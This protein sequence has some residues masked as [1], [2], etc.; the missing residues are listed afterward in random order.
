MYSNSMYMRKKN[1]W[2]NVSYFG[3]SLLFY[4]LCHYSS[5][6]LILLLYERRT[7]FIYLFHLISDTVLT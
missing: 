6:L 7:V 5:L 2:D 3:S 4:G 1:S